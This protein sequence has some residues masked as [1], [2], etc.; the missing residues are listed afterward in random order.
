MRLVRF[1]CLLAAGTSGAALLAKIYGVTSMR[2]AT[3]ALALPCCIA[4][5]I[6]W[7]WARRSSHTKLATM[8]SLGFLG[9][10]FGTFAY[11]IVRIPFDLAGQRI[12]GPIAAYGIWINDA[13][14][15]SRFTDVVGWAYH[16]SNGITF[17]VMYALFF[18]GR[19]WSW[20]VAW[21]LVLETIALTSPFAGIFSIAGNYSAISIAYM[22]HIAWGIPLGLIVQ[23]HRE[24]EEFFGRISSTL[25][26]SLLTLAC[27]ALTSQIFFTRNIERD[28]SVVPGEFRR[29]GD[30]LIPSW[31]RLQH[32][33]RVS[34][35]NPANDSIWVRVLD[36]DVRIPSRASAVVDF[37]NTGVYQ[38]FVET[39]RRSRSSFVI[40]EPVEDR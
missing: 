21:G 30:R 15:S 35:R 11:D 19:P 2:A 7:I 38:V 5:V 33:G 1:A 3:L 12:F 31:Q 36:R 18:L 13:A 24:V 9:G 28:K 39:T 29:E 22:G 26:W 14:S 20:A 25:K 6:T 32:A 27:V 4:L 23:H 37:P 40:V 8:L 10:L 34:I 16:F 17:G